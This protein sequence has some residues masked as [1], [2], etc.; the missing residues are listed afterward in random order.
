LTVHGVL[1]DFLAA[2]D[3]EGDVAAKR[4][5]VQDRGRN[6]GFI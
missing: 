3:I 5:D 4:N 2:P 1:L 6:A